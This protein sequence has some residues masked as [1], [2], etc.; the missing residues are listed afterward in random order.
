MAD[1]KPWYN[2]EK[3]S[4]VVLALLYINQR[5]RVQKPRVLCLHLRGYRR[6][7][8]LFSAFLPYRIRTYLKMSVWKPIFMVFHLKGVRKRSLK[9]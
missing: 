4:E 9:F 1:R 6:L 7:V 2:E 8:N 3:V 5:I